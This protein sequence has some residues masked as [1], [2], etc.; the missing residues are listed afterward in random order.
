MGPSRTGKTNWAR[1]IGPHLYWNGMFNLDLFTK[2]QDIKYAIF[3]D[4]EDW[5]RFY[6]YKCWLGAQAEFTV[7]D[8]Y[9]KKMQIK[10]GKPAIVL[11]NIDPMF[12]DND[13]ISKNCIKYVM[14][15]NERFY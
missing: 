4:W 3:D 11:S 7:T 5:S 12:S 9:R 6:N 8:K 2:S 13:W 15:D 14:S 1:S 10:W